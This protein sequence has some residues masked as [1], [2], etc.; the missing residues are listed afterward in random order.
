MFASTERL[1]HGPDLVPP[2]AEDVI[3][4]A[5]TSHATAGKRT[6]AIEEGV[7]LPEQV[8]EV[9]LEEWLE[10]GDGRELLP[11]EPG[12]GREDAAEQGEDVATPTGELAD[13]VEAI[14]HLVDATDDGIELS[15]WD[16]GMF[17]GGHALGPDR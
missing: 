11:A 10:G 15:T 14:P 17:T 2:G 1:P 5:S 9:P 6:G 4:Q 12:A 7:G 13:C 8:Q 3:A 16:H